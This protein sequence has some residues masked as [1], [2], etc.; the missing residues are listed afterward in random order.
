MPLPPEE[1]IAKEM[2]WQR[3]K[4]DGQGNLTKIKNFKLYR[5]YGGRHIKSVYQLSKHLM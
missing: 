2:G 3:W 4:D 5:R 1:D